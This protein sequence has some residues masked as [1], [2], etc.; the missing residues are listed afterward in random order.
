MFE[1]I[2]RLGVREGLE[3]IY[4]GEDALQ[5]HMLLFILVAIPAMLTTPLH[6]MG[7]QLVLTNT[8]FILALLGLGVIA[9]M[10]VYI[11][12]YLYGVMHNAFNEET[13]ELL[14]KFDTSWFKIFFKGFPVQITWFA[15]LFII[16]VAVAI[17][18]ALL[19]GLILPYS[20]RMI[21]KI[22]LLA[23]FLVMN[24]FVLALPFVYAQ[25]T[26]NYDRKG[27][28]NPIL[29]IKYMAK[30]FK[31]FVL[32]LLTFAPAFVLLFILGYFGTQSSV[33]AYLLTAIW[34]YLW[35]IM[36]YSA[37]YCYIKI[38]KNEIKQ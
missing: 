29:P 34:A 16:F 32:L 36:Q 3:K 37:N 26:E 7:E 9:V 11:A 21:S 19:G 31:S 15:Y 22:A 30:A 24:V 5:K 27:L 4:A 18:V 20:T 2:E 10:S 13:R 1:F 35:T 38:Y 8:Q 6:D 12:G 23:A 14:P 28:Y 17:V 33:F 25:F